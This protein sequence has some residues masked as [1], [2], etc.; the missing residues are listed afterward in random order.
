MYTA[1]LLASER[2]Q[3]HRGACAALCLRAPLTLRNWAANQAQKPARKTQLLNRS[4]TP[5]L[6]RTGM[7]MDAAA[8][9]AIAAGRCPASSWPLHMKV[10]HP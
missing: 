8:T 1:A 7:A 3:L 10:T 2:P 5:P 9:A 6:G 4:V